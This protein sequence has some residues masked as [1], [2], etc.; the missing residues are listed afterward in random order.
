LNAE[1]NTRLEFY[2]SCP[3]G[4]EK[5]VASE[6]SFMGIKNTRPLSGG[7]AFFGSLEQA[8]RACLWLRSA[9]RVLLVLQ[10]FSAC[11]AQELYEGARLIPWQQHLT[12]MSTF[13]VHARGVNDELRNTQF[14]ALKVKDALCDSLVELTGERPNVS[15][16]RPD[17]RLELSLRGNK[18]TL[19]LDLSGEPL[20]RRGY[21]TAGVQTEAPMKENLAAGVLL[22]SGWGLK[23]RP[24]LLFDPL[25]GSGTFL[26]EAACIAFDRA[27]GLTRDHWGFVGW[28]GHDQFVWEQLIDE[29]DQ[30][31]ESALDGYFAGSSNC[32][33][34]GSSTCLL[35]GSDYD[36]RAIEM[37]RESAKKLG[38][39][40]ILHFEVADID[41]ARNTLERVC[42]RQS[43]GVTERQ[44]GQKGDGSQGQKGDGS[45]L[46][47]SA[48]TE[49]NRPLFVLNRPLFV[50]AV[51][52]PQ[53]GMIVSN[54]PYAHRVGHE[55]ELPALYRKLEAALVGLP[56]DWTLHLITPDETLEQ[57][58]LRTPY[59]CE[60]L[61]NGKIETRLRHYRLGDNE[62]NTL[63]V[64][65]PADGAIVEITTLEAGTEQFV[66]RLKK[67]VRERRKWAKREGVSCYRLYDSD[68]PDYAVAID[69]YEGLQNSVERVYYSVAEYKAPK[70][71]DETKA[72]RR[73]NDVLTVLP[74]VLGVEPEQI[75]SKLREQARGGEQY[76]ESGRGATQLVV[77]ENGLSFLVDLS[78]Y[79]DTGIFLDHRQTRALV[80]S[81]AQGKTFLNLFA[82]TGAATVYAAAGGAATTTTVD[83][84]NTYTG[85]AQKNMSLNGFAGSNRHRFIRADVFEW[86]KAEIAA[87]NTYDLIF[88]D[89]PTFSNS[90]MMTRQSWSVQR[91]HVELLRDV[92][93]L[94]A[95]DGRVIFSCNLR[96]FKLDSEGLARVGI[97]AEDI[98]AG[99][100]PHDFV[101]NPKIHKCY[102]LSASSRRA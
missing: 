22:M 101:R 18:A 44:K 81:L 23:T 78:S 19:Y 12:P 9:S 10:R 1:N 51:P 92:M 49:M 96:T 41:N 27:P 63:L 40:D 89:P 34:G 26:L 48:K 50:Q 32:G 54:P 98:T 86:L 13:A 80:R 69:R 94:L 4:L 33:S 30:R 97:T 14:T 62:R 67:V 25:C 20:H 17:I 64:Q 35:I 8:Y 74:A 77:R 55:D 6:L 2:A 39:S 93:A 83:L 65:C 68:L 52:L 46:S 82:Y 7:V 76:G 47:C 5:T 36:R 71:I 38:L 45:F 21:R 59:Q 53:T 56:S 15:S 66:A 88:V 58:L 87:G 42:R 100:I 70:E 43:D 29:A 72:L 61:Y 102:L 16:E 79:L 24:E 3:F 95:K 90:K 31:F 99:T 84:S 37:A 75:I 91:D 11:N 73:Y 28:L 57:H 85:W 60:T